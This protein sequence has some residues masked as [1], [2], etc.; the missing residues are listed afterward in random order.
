VDTLLTQNIDWIKE[1]Q[2]HKRT[3]RQMCSEY[4]HSL[5]WL[6][7]P[8]WLSISWHAIMAQGLCWHDSD[9]TQ[10]IANI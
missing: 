9:S 1:K 5:R 3:D 2:V 8:S 4:Q 6:C 10:T 7:A